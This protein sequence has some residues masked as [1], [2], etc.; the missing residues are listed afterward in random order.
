[1]LDT[2]VFFGEF[3]FR[4]PNAHISSMRAFVYVFED[5]E[6]EDEK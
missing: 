5:N 2:T 4:T 1:M 3:D 6:P